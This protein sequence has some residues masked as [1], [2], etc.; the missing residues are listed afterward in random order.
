MAEQKGT[1]VA[2]AREGRGTKSFLCDDCIYPEG[3]MLVCRICRRRLKVSLA[4]LQHIGQVGKIPV[5]AGPGVVLAS[6]W[7]PGCS[8]LEPETTNADIEIYTVSS[9]MN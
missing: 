9:F 8:H 7:L 6:S 2:C 3:A 1:C 4:G 5:P